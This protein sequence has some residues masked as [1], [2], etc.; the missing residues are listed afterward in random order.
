L[1]FVADE[2]VFVAIDD[3]A[4]EGDGSLAFKTGDEI[5][6]LESTPEG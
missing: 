2:F 1:T 4:G 5:K 3:C 6:I